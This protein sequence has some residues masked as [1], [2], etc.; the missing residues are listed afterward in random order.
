M[1]PLVAIVGRPNVGKSRL[2]NRLMR[3]RK[4][5]VQDDA[6]VTRDRHYGLTHLDGRTI[7]LVD[8]GGLVPD[9][10]DAI[11]TLVREQAEIAIEE[12]DL[13]VMVL[14]AREGLTAA[15]QDVADILRRTA[16]PVIYVANKV[17]GPQQE[18]L[19]LEFFSLG[20][21]HVLNISAEHG[22]GVDSL[23]DTLL[24]RLGEHG[25]Q[26]SDA[27]ASEGEIRV[28]LVGRPNAGK[29]SLLNHLAGEQRVIVSE[30]PGTTRDP[31][32]VQLN[33]PDGKSFVLVDTAGIRRKKSKSTTMERYA[34]VRAM[35]SI[36][37]ADVACLLI[38]AAAGVADQDAKLADMAL[39]AGRGLVLVLNKSDLL[40]AGAVD[41]KKVQKQLQDKLQ[42]AAFAPHLFISSK[43][44]KGVGK[45]LPTIRRIH[46]S[47]GRR[48]NTSEL[49][50]F[51]K[52]VTSAHVPPAYRGRPV[53]FYYITQPQ[54]HPPTFVIS[55][56]AARGVHPTYK[57]YMVNRLREEFGF[58]GAPIRLFL[59]QR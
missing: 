4:A 9:S 5:I 3:S 10:T 18:L 25:S 30:Q 41:K 13:L 23:V 36:S 26:L 12:A 46:E 48:I 42:F 1:I 45:L 6:G 56:N 51:L 7:Q 39:E 17:D 49:N 29:S 54:A 58:V 35:R 44:G 50:R 53:R 40:T 33:T 27:A 8:T 28:A 21:D 19:S 57:R 22:R 16:K 43:T 11:E 2:F 34:I 24:Q 47:C 15:D 38:D 20:I 55:T 32:D 59:R 14:D 37:S 52:D 31:V